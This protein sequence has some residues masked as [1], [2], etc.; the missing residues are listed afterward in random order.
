MRRPA[1]EEGFSLVELLVIV[2]IIGVLAGIAISTYLNQTRKAERAAAVST[3]SNMRLAAESIRTDRASDGFSGDPA[4]YEESQGSYQY[5]PADEPS[6]GANVV[7]VFA[8]GDGTWVA[9]AVRGRDEC[10]Y[11]RLEADAETFFQSTD[12][13]DADTECTANEFPSPFTG[14]GAWG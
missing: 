12:D 2:V 5:L 3:L 1:R 9:F 13:L 4:D 6:T 14:T 8:A 10:Y 7:S 11:L